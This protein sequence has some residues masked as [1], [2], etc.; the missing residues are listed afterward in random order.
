MRTTATVITI[1][2]ALA[3]ASCGEREGDQTPDPRTS[4]P[5][6]EPAPQAGAP[7]VEGPTTL[8]GLVF[9]LPEGVELAPSAS[10]MRLAEATMRASSGDG[11]ADL[12]FFYFGAS[13]AGSI[14]DN[15]GRWTTLVVDENGAPAYPEVEMLQERELVTAIVRLDGTYMA[16]PPAGQKTAMPEHSLLGAIIEGG[17][18][19]PVYIRL[20]GPTAVVGALEPSFR[21]MVRS[22]TPA[23]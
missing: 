16:G 18:E 12:I 1:A 7:E 23:S 20:T 17:P 10:A 15:I 9:E 22:A 13:G 8:A 11:E 14:D 6:S 5:V 2:S 21:A 19:G 3:L 4:G